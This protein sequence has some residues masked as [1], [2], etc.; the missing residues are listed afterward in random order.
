LSELI[1]EMKN[2]TI[3]DVAKAAGVSTATVSRVIR[4][5]GSISSVTRE[6]VYAA[7]KNLGYQV[8]L[9]QSAEK[10]VEKTVALVISDI[11]NPFF[12]EVVRGV[13]DEAITSGY[14]TLLYNTSEDPNRELQ[15][16]KTLISRKVMGIIVCSSRVPTDHLLNLQMKTDAFIVVVNRRVEQ[17]KFA[18][19]TIDFEEASYRAT[20]YLLNL[21]HKKIAYLGGYGIYDASQARF[22]G[23]EKALSD[24]GLVIPPQW[25]IN[26]FPNIGGGFQAMSSL[27]AIDS[28][29]LPTAVVAY[30][31]LVAIGIL[32]AA[33]THNIH[34]P[35]ELSVV[36]FDGI[37][38]SAHTN[39]ALT[40]VEQPK[41]RIGQLAMKTLNQ[42]ISG[43]DISVGGYT[44]IDTNL[45]VRDSTFHPSH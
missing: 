20:K 25:R 15:I 31:D 11:L 9:T 36:G 13:E 27:L 3:K 30:N 38:L 44:H 8:P 33:R 16:F 34:I 35:S 2:V 4:N 19:I 18:S 45:V 22:R 5:K 41:Y 28:T 6:K 21:G 1:T 40:T 26:S 14:S 23:V 12:P 10:S 32:H 17:K 37:E 29:D 24:S 42:M 43:K 7:V 39:P